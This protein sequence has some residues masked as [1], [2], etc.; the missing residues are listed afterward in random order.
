MAYLSTITINGV[1]TAVTRF[2]NAAQ[3]IDDAASK[4]IWQ[5]NDNLILNPDFKD[6]VNLMGATSWTGAGQTIDGWYATKNVNTEAFQISLTDDGIQ[7]TAGSDAATYFRQKFE[8]LL[9]VGTYALSVLASSVSGSPA[10]Q[11]WYEDSTYDQSY[12]LYEGLRAVVITATKKIAR[13]QFT[14]PAGASVVLKSVKLEY[15]NKQT[16]AHQDSDGAWVLNGEPNKTLELMKSLRYVL[17]L[18]TVRIRASRITTSTINFFIPTPVPLRTTPTII[19]SGYLKVCS[20]AGI[21]Q[22]GF[23]ITID[24]VSEAGISLMATKDAHG[25]SDS[26]LAVSGGTVYFDANV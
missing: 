7:I 8:N 15:G 23:T 1:S 2:S 24:G 19:N 18:N 25:L 3:D 12:L 22:S 17:P 26:V 6:P 16:L 20:L 13:V 11:V 5:A 14:I 9:P 4:S 21:I 10:V